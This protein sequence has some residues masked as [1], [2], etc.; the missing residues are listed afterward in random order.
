MI[1]PTAAIAVAKTTET[2][3]VGQFSIQTVRPTSSAV[4]EENARVNQQDNG[5]GYGNVVIRA[6]TETDIVGVTSDPKSIKDSGPQT[7]KKLNNISL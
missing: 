7:T 2:S 1:L 3:I 6:T 4:I 5:D